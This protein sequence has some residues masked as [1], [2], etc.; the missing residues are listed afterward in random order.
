MAFSSDLRKLPGNC[1]EKR[2][3]MLG[4]DLPIVQFML[5]FGHRG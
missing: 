1:A 3:W 2:Q 5:D 4:Q